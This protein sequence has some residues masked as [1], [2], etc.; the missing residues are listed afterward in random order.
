VIPLKGLFETHLNVRSLD[1]SI[2]FYRE[3][4]ELRLAAVFDRRRAAFF[5]IGEPRRAMLGLWETGTTPLT[6]QSH[7]AF[8]TTFE[9][10]LAAPE[11][12]VRKGVSVLD[13]DG[14]PTTEPVVLGWMPAVSV[15]FRDPDGH[16]L[17]CLALLPDPPDPEGRILPWSR[18][19]HR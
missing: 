14:R 18:W 10:V 13:F 11:V 12:L 5:W 8:E 19:R 1:V 9:A 15:Y 6:V 16:L 17:E 2:A 7:L 3:T 4:L